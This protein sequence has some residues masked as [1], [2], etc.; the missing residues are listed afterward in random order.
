[1]KRANGQL[2]FDVIWRIA[3]GRL[4]ALQQLVS[5]GLLRTMKSNHVHIAT[6]IKT[7]TLDNVLDHK[8]D[9][10]Y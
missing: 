5:T 7:L 1:M 4:T 3:F 8:N 2:K 6:D 10:L 9:N